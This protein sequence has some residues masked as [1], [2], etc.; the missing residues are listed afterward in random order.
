MHASIHRYLGDDTNWTNAQV[1][2]L[3][4]ANQP[5]YNMTVESWL[6]QRNYLGSALRLLKNATGFYSQLGETIESTLE[7]L[8][9]SRP[10]EQA[11]QAAGYVFT[12]SNAKGTTTSTTLLSLLSLVTTFDVV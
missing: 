8:V 3:I 10:T 1:H 2:P 5:N 12:G 7:S 6:D 4:E 11:L 9:P